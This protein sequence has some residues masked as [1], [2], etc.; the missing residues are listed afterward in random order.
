M[1]IVW[2]DNGV[3]SRLGNGWLSHLASARYRAIIPALELQKNDHSV[4]ILSVSPSS[5]PEEIFS[6]KLGCLIF[7][8]I[9]TD[10]NTTLSEVCEYNLDLVRIAKERNIRVITDIMDNHFRTPVLSGYYRKLA[11]MSDIIV[12]CSEEMKDIVYRNTLKQSMVISDPAEGERKVAKFFPPKQVSFFSK[13]LSIKNRKQKFTRYLKLLWYGHQSNLATLNLIVPG[14]EKFAK[15]VEIELCIVT[16]PDCGAE[17][18]VENVNNMNIFGYRCH[19]REWSQIAVWEELDKCDLV[20]I[21][22]DKDNS[23]KSGKSPN[24]IIESFWAGRYV[25]AHPIPSYMKFEEWAWISDD[26]ITGIKWALSH[27]DMVSKRIN[28]AQEYISDHHSAK[29]IASQWEKVILM[30][31]KEIELINASGESS[32][33]F[34][35]IRNSDGI[36]RLNLGCGDKILPSYI[37]VDVVEN[38]LDMRPDVLCDLHKLSIFENDYADEILSVHVVEHFWR[39]EVGKILEEWVRVLKPGGKMILE[40]PNLISACE[41]LL[42]DTKLRAQ[43]GQDGQ[44]TMW[45]FYGDPQWHDPLMVHRW[46]YTPD[47]LGELMASVGLVNIYQEPAEYKLREPRDMRVVGYK[48]S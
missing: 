6:S 26:L 48:R 10:S 39:W 47:S 35:D 8:K 27:E 19:F 9:T 12:T 25:V 40:C 11:E 4:D 7:G 1:R 24:R 42:K 15:D 43:P 38:R 13:I 18:Y 37:N 44:R 20:V 34:E 16:A 17:K 5:D 30:N 45:V 21:P 22:S 29:E 14:L 33:G 32:S 2:I 28:A 23:K 41:E 36:V 46:G 3:V 31:D